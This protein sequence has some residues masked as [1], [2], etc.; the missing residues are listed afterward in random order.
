MLPSGPR[1]EHGSRLALK[2]KTKKWQISVYFLKFDYETVAEIS[3]ECPL[4]G[5]IREK[6]TMIISFKVFSAGITDG[7]C[8]ANFA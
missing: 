6:R 1:A 4:G 7:D 5:G 2:Y 3:L 8:P